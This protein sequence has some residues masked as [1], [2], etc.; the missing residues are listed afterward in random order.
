MPDTVLAIKH[1]L[2][3]P[4]QMNQNAYKKSRS[5]WN[6]YLNLISQLPSTCY[7]SSYSNLI[8]EIGLLNLDLAAA[9][10]NSLFLNFCYFCFDFWI[11]SE[12]YYF[13]STQI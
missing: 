12:D 3:S 2:S 1:R 7:Y 13:E 8:L 11:Y 10:C 5:F 6:K 9:S 4:C